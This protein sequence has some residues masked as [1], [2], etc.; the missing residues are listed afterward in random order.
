[1]K[2]TLIP[3][4]RAIRGFTLME[5]MLVL[6]IIG[7]LV[8]VTTMSL[9]GV[10]EDA[11]VTKAKTGI[12][13]LNIHLLSFRTNTGGLLPTQLEGL[14]AR[15]SG[16]GKKPW[17]Q[18]A[19]ENELIDPWGSPYV[20]RNPGKQNPTGFDLFSLGPD[21]KEGTDDDVWPE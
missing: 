7:I 6:G 13:D 21:K 5:M 9:S 19:K 2:H 16:L 12:R 17:R 3:T 20:Y 4:Q 10:M 11:K 1:M 18:Y 8:T 14:V 15:P